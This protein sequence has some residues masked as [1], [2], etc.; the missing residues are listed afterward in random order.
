MSDDLTTGLRELAESGQAPPTVSGAEIRRR[1]V[2][3]RRRRRTA[4]GVAGASAATVVAAALLIGVTRPGAEDRPSPASIPTSGPSTPGI[5]AAPVARVD[6]IRRVLTLGGRKV[7]VT[8]GRFRTRTPTGRLTVTGR[9]DVMMLSGKELGF[10]DAGNLKV[11]WAVRLRA[12]DGTVTYFGGVLYDIKASGAHDVTTG[13]IGL[14]LMDAKWLYAQLR[15]GD[16]VD[17]VGRGSSTTTTTTTPSLTRTTASGS[18]MSMGAASEAPPSVR[19]G[20]SSVRTRTPSVHA[21]TS[22]VHAGT[23]SVRTGTP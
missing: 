11:P 16:V 17:I 9:E 3:R 15:V 14:N 21:G 22:S 20:T 19:T 4:A 2:A 5:Q 23:S 1:A 6:L 12:D 13:W 18:G 7:P 10:R 8:S